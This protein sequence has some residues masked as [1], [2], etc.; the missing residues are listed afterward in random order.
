MTG[1]DQELIERLIAKDVTLWSGSGASA[2]ELMS[3]MG[4]LDAVSWMEANSGDI[5]KWADGVAQ[6]D[7]YK[8]VILLGMGGSSLAAEVFAKFFGSK[9]GYPELVVLDTTS[10]AQI[11]NANRD[12]EQSLFIVASKSGTTIESADLYSWFYAELEKQ[13]QNPADNFVAITDENSWLHNEAV[14][15]GFTKIFLNPANIGGRYSALS[16]FGLVP[17]ALVGVDIGKVFEQVEKFYQTVIAGKE[18]FG[19]VGLAE[20][21]AHNSTS[22]NHVLNLYLEAP[23]DALV[24]WIEQLVAESTG[25]NDK[26]ILPI[27][28]STEK[29]IADSGFNVY[30]GGNPDGLKGKPSRKFEWVLKDHYDISREFLRWEM[31]TALAA[32]YLDINPF[33][34]PDVENA[35]QRTRTF[36]ETEKV[37]P[38]ANLFEDEYLSACCNSISISVSENSLF[39]RIM[40]EFQK[41]SIRGSYLAILAYLPMFNEEIDKLEKLRIKIQRR[42][43][44]PT[45]VGFGPRYLHSTGQFHK[46][47]PATGCFLQIIEE[48][49]EEIQIPERKYGFYKLHRAQADGDYSVIE[50]NQR[51]IMRIS[52][53]GDRLRS[54]DQLLNQF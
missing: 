50:G 24:P 8:K 33:D 28:C 17:A 26:G 3:R 37:L 7:I 22:G 36:V 30:I 53:K 43:S 18:D 52:L 5:S 4:W 29:L 44:V 16:Y 49:H 11:V 27:S 34:Q 41:A 23:Y 46:G 6:A 1:R 35:K 9:S 10:P 38:I 14:D 19:I 42:F 51:P 39:N 54:L 21:M 13:I 45:S 2:P 32:S 20:C 47:G 31:V 40:D 48:Q 15:K 12:I 25:K